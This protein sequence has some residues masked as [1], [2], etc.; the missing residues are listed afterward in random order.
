VVFVHA[1]LCQHRDGQGL[2]VVD[3]HIHGVSVPSS[4]RR[5][6][7]RKACRSRTCVQASGRA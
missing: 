5:P 7:L 1:M 6:L 4:A 2:G 3:L